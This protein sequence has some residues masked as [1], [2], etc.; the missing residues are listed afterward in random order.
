MR[1]APSKMRLVSLSSRVSRVRAAWGKVG[2]GGEEVVVG[3]VFF[4]GREGEG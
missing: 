2:G 3:V 1:A 4:R